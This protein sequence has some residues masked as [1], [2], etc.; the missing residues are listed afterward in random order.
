MIT[1]TVEGKLAG[2]VA[3]VDAVVDGAC[4]LETWWSQGDGSTGA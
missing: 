3:A 2:A 1:W 4:D